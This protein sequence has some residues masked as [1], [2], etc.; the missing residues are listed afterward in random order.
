MYKLHLS[1]IF[2]I[3]KYD[4]SFWYQVYLV[5]FRSHIIYF[6][7]L[8]LMDLKTVYLVFET[9]TDRPIRQIHAHTPWVKNLSYRMKIASKSNNLRSNALFYQHFIKF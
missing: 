4:V 9:C 5:P 7:V 1:G 6:L 3:N 8:H 2:I